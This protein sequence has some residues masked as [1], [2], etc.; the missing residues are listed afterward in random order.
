MRPP[1]EGHSIFTNPSHAS[2]EQRAEAIEMCH[3]CPMKVWCARQAIRAGDTL[4]GEHPSPA[5]DVIQAGVWLKGSA[6]KTA[7]LYRQV[8]MT[9]AERQRRKPT[10]KCCLNCKKPMVPRDKKVHLTPDTLTHAARGYCRICYAALKRRGELAT[11]HPK[12]QAALGWREKRTTRKGN[13]S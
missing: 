12:H 5:L 8:G 4:D 3:H 13:D 7:D 2:P 11:L 1:C 10:P 6:E 9:P